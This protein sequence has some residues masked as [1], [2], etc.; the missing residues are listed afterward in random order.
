MGYKKVLVGCG[1]VLGHTSEQ[2]LITEYCYAK[3]L[4]F[5]RTR[6]I[7]E[8]TK[9]LITYY[10]Y[11]LSALQQVHFRL[12]SWH[13]IVS[14]FGFKPAKVEPCQYIRMMKT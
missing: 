2:E 11:K 1:I 6:A 7:V 14:A 5:T 8:S 3:L 9:I 12:V 4:W 10:Y 13:T